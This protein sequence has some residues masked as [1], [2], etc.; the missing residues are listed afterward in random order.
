MTNLHS[1]KAPD[2]LHGHGD[3]LA[4]YFWAAEHGGSHPMNHVPNKKFHI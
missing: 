1:K 2:A 3:K 4:Y